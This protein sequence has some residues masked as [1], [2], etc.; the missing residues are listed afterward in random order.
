[1]DDITWKRHQLLPQIEEFHKEAQHF[2]DLTNQDSPNESPQDEEDSW[3][4]GDG[5]DSDDDNDDD[6]DWMADEGE[7]DG[8]EVDESGLELVDE[9]HADECDA[10]EPETMVLYLPSTQGYSACLASQKTALMDQEIQLRTGQAND[11]LSQ[12]RASISYKHFLFKVEYRGADNYRRKAR[13]SKAIRAVTKN[14]NKHVKAYCLAFRALGC[15]H[16]QGAFQPLTWKDL[17]PNKDVI[18]ANRIGQ[19]T[20]DV[21]WIWR[22][23]EVRQHEKDNQCLQQGEQCPI[24]KSSR[25]HNWPIY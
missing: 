25:V 20:D 3:I 17:T 7:G 21:S 15:L 1:M 22:T 6:N 16:A 9:T 5:D 8:F 2:L 10:M 23:G 24:L 11:A 14:I 4:Y 12:I 18:H 19:S 13:S